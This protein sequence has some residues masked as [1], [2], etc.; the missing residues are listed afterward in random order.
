[1]TARINLLITGI[2]QVD[3]VTAHL[4]SAHVPLS[5]LLFGL[6]VE[7]NLPKGRGQVA[8]VRE[9]L[10]LRTVVPL[11][12]AVPVAWFAPPLFTRAVA[13]A[14]ICAASPVPETVCNLAS[15]HNLF[16]LLSGE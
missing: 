11:L 7:T 5:I 4:A 8:D 12:L 1:M 10:A 16:C 14:S 15:D 9:V 13:A 3:T 6:S 2:L